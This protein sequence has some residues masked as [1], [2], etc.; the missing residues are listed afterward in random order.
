MSRIQVRYDRV[1]QLP[2]TYSETIPS[3]YLDDMG[4][5]NVRWYTHLFSEGSLGFMR[6]IGL[7]WDQIMAQNGGTFVLE[8]HKSVC[9]R[10][11]FSFIFLTNF[12]LC[13]YQFVRIDI[14]SKRLRTK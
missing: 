2:E 5:M 6:Q 13:S 8:S 7:H 1:L 11:L 10:H 14:L 4:H 9:L 12:V 3:D